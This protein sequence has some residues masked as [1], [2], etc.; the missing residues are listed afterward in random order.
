M[1]HPEINRAKTKQTK[2]ATWR[3]NMCGN[4]ISLLDASFHLCLTLDIPLCLSRSF[5]FCLQLTTLTI[6]PHDSVQSFYLPW[7]RGSCQTLI[8]KWVRAA[9]VTQLRCIWGCLSCSGPLQLSVT[10]LQLQSKWRLF[11]ICSDVLINVNATWQRGQFAVLS[12]TH[13]ASH[14]VLHFQTCICTQSTLVVAAELFSDSDI[15]LHS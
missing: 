1:I 7:Q 4:R 15:C 13:F 6:C 8:W 2:K 14:C 5:S 10:W 12:S 3:Y 9:S 11:S